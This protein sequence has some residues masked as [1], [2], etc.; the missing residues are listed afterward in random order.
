MEA[1]KRFAEPILVKSSLM[2]S[3]A[4]IGLIVN[5]YVVF[6]L[7]DSD[8]LNIK[9]AFLHILTDALASIG[10]IVPSVWIFSPGK[11]S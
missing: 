3:V 11:L 9:T 2:F 5:L 6:K 7:C 10:V 1:I 4:F 8:D